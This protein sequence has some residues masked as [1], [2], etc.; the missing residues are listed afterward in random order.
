MTRQRRYQLRMVATGRC[1]V[2]GRPVVPGVAAWC[3]WHL[4]VSRIRAR[5]KHKG[6]PY[7]G[8]GRGR[9]PL[10]TDAELVAMMETQ[11]QQEAS[12]GHGG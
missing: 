8:S 10:Y 3:A 6:S 4:Y 9:R 5:K 2:C 11:F 12:N 1:R 7:A